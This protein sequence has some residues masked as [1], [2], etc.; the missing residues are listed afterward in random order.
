MTLSYNK[1]W[2]SAK[3]YIIITLGLTMYSFGFCA[4][5]LPEKVIIGGVTGFSTIV[6]FLTQN[7]LGYG[8]PVAVT[9]YAV[10]ALLLAIAW[11]KVGKTFVIRTIF[12]ATV[13]SLGIGFFQPFF[14]E[15]I[16]K[17]QDFMN[18]LIGAI[19][20]GFGVGRT[21]IHNG[22]TG[23][24][25]IVAANRSDKRHGSVRGMMI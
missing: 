10:N 8:V 1:L 20:A 18:V 23:G 3:D 19:M 16:V 14:H 11:R 24:K 17:G 9:A 5:V 13:L 4:F 12:G 2:L 25:G 6:Y 7:H 22:A 21:Y 15:P